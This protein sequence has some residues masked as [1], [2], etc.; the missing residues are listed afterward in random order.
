MNVIIHKKYLYFYATFLIQWF[1]IAITDRLKPITI[2]IL[3]GN[4]GYSFMGGGNKTEYM[5][6]NQYLEYVLTPCN[7]L[8][9]ITFC[10]IMMSSC[11][12]TRYICKV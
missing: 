8:E 2:S 7:M 3:E 6:C 1:S 11:H 4:V 5:L 12:F 10:S 9:E